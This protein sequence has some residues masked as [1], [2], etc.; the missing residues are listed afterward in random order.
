MTKI[1]VYSDTYNQLHF[2]IYSSAFR[3][4]VEERVV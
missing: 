2:I 1:Q 4:G 3:W